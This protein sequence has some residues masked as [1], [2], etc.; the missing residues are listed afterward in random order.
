MSRAYRLGG[1]CCCADAKLQEQSYSQT[2]WGRRHQ[3]G[4]VSYGFVHALPVQ[5]SLEGA[6][7]QEI[8]SSSRWRYVPMIVFTQVFNHLHHPC[9]K[10]D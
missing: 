4:S 6:V 2:G 1:N 8:L 3:P 9:W 5:S 7:A 10:T